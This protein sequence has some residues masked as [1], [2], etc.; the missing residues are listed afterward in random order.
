MWTMAGLRWMGA[1]LVARSNRKQSILY[2]TI[3]Y[4]FWELRDLLRGLVNKRSLSFLLHKKFPDW[5][6]AQ[7]PKV[8]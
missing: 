6:L 8:Q 7:S 3:S 2:H 5:E 1:P 4:P